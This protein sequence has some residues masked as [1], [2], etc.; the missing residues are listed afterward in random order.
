[1]THV[2]NYAIPNDELISITFFYKERGGVARWSM[3]WGQA[4][5]F[6]RINGT[7]KAGA[8]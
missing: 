6:D 7:M 4:L 1:M 8:G 5:R 2:L 3:P